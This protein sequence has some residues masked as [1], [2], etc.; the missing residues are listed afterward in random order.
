[1]LPEAPYHLAVL[2]LTESD[3]TGGWWNSSDLDQGGRGRSSE[4]DFVDYFLDDLTLLARDAVTSRIFVIS[5]A[6]NLFCKH[7]L[8]ELF[9]SL[10]P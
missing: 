5:C 10:N 7:A 4:S 1:M 9:E 2:V 8:G 6:V 3:P